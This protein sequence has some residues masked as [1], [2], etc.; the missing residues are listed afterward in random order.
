AVNLYPLPCF[1]VGARQSD[2]L[3]IEGHLA[4]IAADPLAKWVYMGDG[5]ECVTYLSKGVIYQQVYSPQTQME[6]LVK[7]LR[8]LKDK[9]LFMIRGNHGGRI[10]K[11]SGLSFDKNLALV[12]GLPYLGVE[13]FVNLVVNRTHYDL[14]FHHGVDSGVSL[15]TKTNKAEQFSKYISSDAIFTAHS[16]VGMELPPAPLK[17]L[18]NYTMKIKTL[19]R[20]QYICGSGYD[21]RSGYA[22]DKGY[23]PLLPQFIMVSFSGERTS[24]QSIKG[25]QYRRWHSDGTH[26]VNGV[27]SQAQ[28]LG[29]E[30]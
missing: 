18:D 7:L 14:F 20:Y 21:S 6:V 16:H 19:L 3:F 9:G 11:E 2:R 25:Q 13:A 23:T 17:Y 28:H 4:R 24:K 26:E 8:P 1:H 5:G 29:E 30:E 22:Q 27:Y 10:F 12:L 15:Q